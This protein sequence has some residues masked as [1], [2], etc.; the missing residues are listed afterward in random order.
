MKALR[1]LRS[2][3][4][5]LLV[6]LALV[7]VPA[8]AQTEG[9]PRDV[10]LPDDP[11]Y[12]E[13]QRA[14]AAAQMREQIEAQRQLQAETNQRAQAEAQPQA[15]AAQANQ[16]HRFQTISLRVGADSDRYLRHQ[17]FLVYVTPVTSPL[18][19]HDASFRIIQG[20]G[21]QCISLESI[22]YPGHFLRHQE[23]RL[24]L[25]PYEDSQQF[26]QDATFCKGTGLAD[27]LAA[28]YISLNYPSYYLRIE[29]GELWLRQYED[30]DAFRRD[31]TFVEVEPFYND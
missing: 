30:S 19:G 17:N 6:L 5:S 18:D 27:G 25:A 13:R 8:A 15:W 1:R 11:A 2:L 4:G 3:S 29:N 16:F 28:S 23:F 9:V 31:A 22:N 21:G 24:K 14:E 26:R 10:V 20:L 12:E 7:S